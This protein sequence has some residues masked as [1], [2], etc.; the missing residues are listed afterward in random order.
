MS[1]LHVKYFGR[2]QLSGAMY[3]YYDRWVQLERVGPVVPVALRGMQ[4]QRI[5]VDR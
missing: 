4:M 5:T 2:H 3:L 1:H